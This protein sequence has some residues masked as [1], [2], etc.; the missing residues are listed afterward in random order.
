[1]SQVRPLILIEDEKQKTLIQTQY[2][3][4]FIT[5]LELLECFPELWERLMQ[6]KAVAE[7]QHVTAF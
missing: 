6:C 5:P 2:F 3:S 1:M 4:L 7:L